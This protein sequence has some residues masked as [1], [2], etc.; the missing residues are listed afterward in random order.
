MTTLGPLLE[1]PA[2]MWR[3]SDAQHGATE[4]SPQYG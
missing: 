3:G 1:A 4:R 2:L